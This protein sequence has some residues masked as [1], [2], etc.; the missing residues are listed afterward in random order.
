[1][2]AAN[3]EANARRGI[4]PQA[5]WARQ[6]YLGELQARIAWTRVKWPLKPGRSH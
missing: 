4:E 6:G 2:V 1:M 3:C 5:T